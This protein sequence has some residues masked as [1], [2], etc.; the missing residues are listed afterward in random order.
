MIIH[1]QR[2]KKRKKFVED[3]INK[4]PIVSSVIDAVDGDLLTESEINSIYSKNKIYKTKYPFI[5]NTGEIGCFLSHRKA[6]QRIVDQKLDAGLIIEDD[7][8]INNSIF[9]KAFN[10]SVKHIKEYKYIQFQVRK[11]NR[12]SEIIQADTQLQLLKPL[13]SYLRTSAQ[14]VSFEAATELLQKTQK[15]DRPVDT[16][17]QMFWET[18]II[19]YC[20]NRSGITDHTIEAGGST[21]I[22]KQKSSFN[23]SKN[24][25]RFIYRIKIFYLS[26]YKKI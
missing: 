3:I 6:W 4:I 18:K 1:L 16:T 11:T 20:V 8:R 19:C 23:I 26:K 15:I 2:A 14:L 7:V 5:I 10:F 9:V 25:K 17:L 24:I 12:K 21:L 22:Q 13:P